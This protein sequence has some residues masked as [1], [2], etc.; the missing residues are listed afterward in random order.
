MREVESLPGF[1]GTVLVDAAALEDAS[2]VSRKHGMVTSTCTRDAEARIHVII[3]Q[4]HFDGFLR[5]LELVT[6]MDFSLLRDDMPSATAH[7]GEW[8]MLLVT[9]L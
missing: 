3:S 7:A 6:G 5:E 4:E 2:S 8:C 1:S 9:L